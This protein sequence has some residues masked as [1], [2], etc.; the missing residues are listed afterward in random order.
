[1]KR[2]QS[3]GCGSVHRQAEP[4]TIEE[5][6]LWDKKILGDHTPE[7]LLNTMIFMI[8]ALRSGN[9]QDMSHA[10]FKQLKE[11]VRDHTYSIQKTSTQVV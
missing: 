4:L 10:K 9:E 6:M 2:L 1:M 8:F 3:K 5:E 11:K 7:T